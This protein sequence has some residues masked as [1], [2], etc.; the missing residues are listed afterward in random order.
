MHGSGCPTA[1]KPHRDANDTGVRLITAGPGA[2]VDTCLRASRADREPRTR[3]SSASPRRSA[4]ACSG[5]GVRRRTRRGRGCRWRS[6]SPGSWRCASPRRARTWRGP[7]RAAARSAAPRCCPPVWPAWPASPTS[8]GAP[9]PAAT[10]ATVFGSYVLPSRPVLAAVGLVVVVTGLAVAG[11]DLDRRGARGRWSAGSGSCCSWRCSSGSPARAVDRSTSPPRSP[12][13]HRPRC[14]SARRRRGP[15]ACSR[16]RGCC[17]SPSSA[18]RACSRS[19]SCA[20]RAT[21]G[22]PSA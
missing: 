11:V 5:S 21:R 8:W 6:S 9:R 13:R 15:R 4:P 17:S 20:T 2:R 22:G 10:A 16:R 12:R 3:S 1:V 7:I 19:A 18:S 14:R